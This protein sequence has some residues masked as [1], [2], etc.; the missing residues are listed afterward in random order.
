[1][2]TTNR[3]I[4]HGQYLFPLYSVVTSYDITCTFTFWSAKSSVPWTSLTFVTT[5]PSRRRTTSMN[6]CQR[7]LREGFPACSRNLTW[8][9]PRWFWL[10]QRSSKASGNTIFSAITPSSH[11]SGPILTLASWKMLERLWTKPKW[12]RWWTRPA[13]SSTVRIDSLRKDSQ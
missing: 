4:S 1:M 5:R 3:K 6:L 12:C 8:G 13:A 7:R 9:T 2:R 10:T 11:P